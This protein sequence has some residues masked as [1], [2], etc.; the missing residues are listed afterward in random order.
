MITFKELL[1]SNPAD[2][3]KL[4]A[5]IRAHAQY[6]GISIRLE[7]VAGTFATVSVSQTRLIGNKPPLTHDELTFIGMKDVFPILERA[8]YT[9]Y[10]A[11]KAY[12]NALQSDQVPAN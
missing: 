6:G 9:S 8:G 1:A 3:A 7:V 4:T 2:Y 10:F 5:T 12:Q 11:I